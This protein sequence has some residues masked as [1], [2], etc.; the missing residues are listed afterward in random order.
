MGYRVV[1]YKG[2][3]QDKLIRGEQFTN[4]EAQAVSMACALIAQGGCLNLRIEDGDGRT[5]L[6]ERELMPRCKITS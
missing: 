1:F 6:T 4:T 3:R 2:P 5:V